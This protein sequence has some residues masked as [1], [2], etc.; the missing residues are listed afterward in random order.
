MFNLQSGQNALIYVTNKGNNLIN[1]RAR[2]IILVHDTSSKC[3]LQMYEM[4]L[5]YL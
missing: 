1:K 2:V 4:S 5:K 3:A